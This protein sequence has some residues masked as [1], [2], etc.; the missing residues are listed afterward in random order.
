[1]KNFI[2]KRVV[3][4]S[5]TQKSA[6][7]FV[8]Q[9]KYNLITGGLDHSVGKTS[10]VKAMLW[11][12]GCEPHDLSKSWKALD[13]KVYVECDIGEDQCVIYR[14]QNIMKL[15]VNG[16]PFQRF[17]K[18]TG[19]YASVFADL[20]GFSVL[21]PNRP[22]KN[23]EPVLETPPPAYY[24]LPFY[25][26][27]KK[28]WSEVW[29]GF[30][31]LGQ[32][33]DWKRKVIRFH[34]GYLLPE[35]FG[36]EEE[37]YEYKKKESVAQNEIKRINTALEVVD[38]Y[39]PRT[40]FTIDNQELEK[41]TKEVRETLR[42]LSIEQENILNE[43]SRLTSDKYHLDAQLDLVTEASQELEEDYKFSVENIEGDELECPLCGTY[44]D[45]TII[46]KA[47]ILADKQQLKMQEN[48][49]RKQL[50][51][52]DKNISRLNFKL[53]RVR[54]DIQDIN[55][56]YTIED[57]EGKRLELVDI[58]DSLASSAVQKNVTHTKE[59]KQ[60]ASK[61]A[62]DK[63]K[64][65]KKEQGKLLTKKDKEERNEH[66]LARLESNI[67]KLSAS[68]VNLNGVKSPEDHRKILK[69]GG[70]AESTRAI[71]AYHASTIDMIKT[72]GSEALA[73]FI[74]DTP[75]QHEQNDFSYKCIIDLIL[76]GLP[77]EQQIFLCALNDPV[78]ESYKEKA[79][80]ITL[81]KKDKLL[82]NG[83]YKKLRDELEDIINFE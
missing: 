12:I 77:H 1:M 21:L 80:V 27:Q 31:K 61:K 46:S 30:D 35:Y 10:L 52:L 67:Q 9:K 56:K 8:F 13:C 64:E 28:G 55:R 4:L 72:F 11:A 45:N 83:D 42:E 16:E 81:N 60:L 39:V 70:A 53:D 54:E 65:L 78:I 5:D 14:Y 59:Q 7:Q 34:T 71:L 29:N 44:H 37:I 51:S 41:I 69:D 58:V 57:S 24:F 6:S 23:Q 47:E 50:K 15:S 49:L 79:K 33:A 38:E 17:S 62:N 73:P 26:D 48:G 25:V 82:G 43:L 36:I 20:V 63:Q 66:F 22:P 3:I 18:I 75:R 2:F 74:I 32:F 76:S 68:G 19:Q 40:Q